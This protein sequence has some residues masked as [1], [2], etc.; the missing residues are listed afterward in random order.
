M[1]LKSSAITAIALAAALVVSGTGVANAT[2]TSATGTVTAA[3]VGSFLESAVDSAPKLAVISAE[4]EKSLVSAAEALISVHGGARLSDE[5]PKLV[6][7]SGVGTAVRFDLV[8]PG[9]DP[10]SSVSVIY[11]T[12]MTV[13]ST[14]ETQLT[15]DGKGGGRI[16]LWQDGIYT[17]GQSITAEEASSVVGEATS[18]R[19]ATTQ[20]LKRTGNF[21]T[22]LNNCLAAQGIAAWALALLSAACAAVCVFTAGLGCVACIGAVLGLPVG[23]IAACVTWASG[24][25]G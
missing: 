9:L 15:G 12:D 24:G 21:F 22:D 18:D 10:L 13:S 19:L 6:D 1:K 8:G 25:V 20:K 11:N 3:E 4:E 17:F 2:P 16:D 14:I 7:V 5:A 23:V